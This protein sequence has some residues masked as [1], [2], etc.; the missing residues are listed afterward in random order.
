MAVRSLLLSNCVRI[1]RNAA[2]PE[3]ILG[4]GSRPFMCPTPN[5]RKLS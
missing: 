2:A 3:P 5:T 4:A 1:H